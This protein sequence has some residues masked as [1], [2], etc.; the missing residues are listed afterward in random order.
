MTPA[1]RARLTDKQEFEAECRAV[2]ERVLARLGIKDA[3]DHARVKRAMLKPVQ[4]GSFKRPVA[5]RPAAPK[6]VELK[7]K[8]TPWPTHT[9]PTHTVAGRTLT[10]RQWAEEL[11]ITYNNMH[12][13]VYRWG[14]V[15]AVVIRRLGGSDQ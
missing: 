13:M 1:E 14:S 15:E 8:A 3:E 5:T 12:Q 11:G 2:R 4:T 9:A 6:P 7:P 10:R